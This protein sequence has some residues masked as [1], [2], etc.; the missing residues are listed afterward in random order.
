MPP[1]N[2]KK[3]KPAANPARGF[4]TVSVPSKPKAP[5]PTASTP[6]TP[7]STTATPESGQP[8]AP[9]T[10]VE[11]SQQS[12]ET[13][14]KDTQ[15]LQN[16]S[17]EELERHLEES[18]LQLLVEKYAAKCRN[19]A[20]RHVTKLETERRL[21]R[22]QAASLNVFEWLPTEVLNRILG[23][24]EMEESELSPQPGAKRALSEEDLYMRLWTLKEALVKLGFSEVKVDESLKHLLLY[25]AGNP[26]PANKDRDF[27]WNLDELLDWL[28][29]HCSPSELPSYAR[30]STALPK[31][32]DKTLSWISGKSRLLVFLSKSNA[33]CFYFPYQRA[34][35][36]SL[37]PPILPKIGNPPSL[38]PIPNPQ[39]LLVWTSLIL[40]ANWS[41]IPWYLNTWNCRRSCTASTQTCSTSQKRARNL[42][43]GMLLMILAIL[44]QLSFSGRSSESKPMCFLIAR[45]PCSNG[46]RNWMS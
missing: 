1:N 36:N 37:Q 44:K 14:P 28:A 20:A 15:S 18:Q 8:A 11:A 31:D 39:F 23:L 35:L 40:I 10:A 45:T 3:K 42:A 46:E 9:T 4:A 6:E 29:L 30:T 34:N 7:E 25:F 26:V 5:E 21:M 24:A 13:Q 33:N 2:K 17:P 43:P 19:D 16:Y 41:R 12:S 27:L 22:Q 32:A 38:H